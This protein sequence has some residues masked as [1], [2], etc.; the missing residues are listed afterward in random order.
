L[1]TKNIAHWCIKELDI[2]LVDKLLL[3][4]N[5]AHIPWKRIE[6][7][8]TTGG[9]IGFLLIARDSSC[10]FVFLHLIV[11]KGSSSDIC[12]PDY[13]QLYSRNSGVQEIIS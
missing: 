5:G 4:A 3:L 9:L 8:L 1:Q 13:H 11:K 2:E 6:F 12:S 10:D 7:C